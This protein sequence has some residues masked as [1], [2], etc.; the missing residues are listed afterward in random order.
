MTHQSASA[1]RH[2]VPEPESH[3]QPIAERDTLN[4][5]PELRFLRDEIEAL[6]GA[7]SV[8]GATHDP[9]IAYLAESDDDSIHERDTE[10]NI[11]AQLVR[12]IARTVG[13]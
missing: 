10:P 12:E 13:K 2:D 1:T 6:L 4:D 8:R 11:D 9:R 3:T 5:T 7:A